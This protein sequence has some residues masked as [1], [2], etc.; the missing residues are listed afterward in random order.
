MIDFTEEITADKLLFASDA[1]AVKD[2]GFGAVFQNR[3]LFAQWE[4]DYIDKYQ[5]SIDYL[6]LYAMIVAMIT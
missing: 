5:P 1:S 3:W 4:P 6:E 2:L